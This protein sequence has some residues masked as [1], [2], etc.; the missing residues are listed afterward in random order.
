MAKDHGFGLSDQPT[1]WQE[2]IGREVTAHVNG[3]NVHG[4]LAV[5]DRGRGYI[6]F[7]P[8]IVAE[9]LITPGGKEYSLLHLVEDIPTRT[10]FTGSIMM[11]P[12]P[13]GTLARIVESSKNRVRTILAKQSESE[14]DPP[15]EQS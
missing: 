13:E 1:N 7:K 2:Y 10:D 4:V 15:Q 6:D 9:H 14:Q 5:I 8:S 11:R 3:Y 12:L